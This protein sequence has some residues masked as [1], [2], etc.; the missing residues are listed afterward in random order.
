[1]TLTYIILTI[2]NDELDYE[3]STNIFEEINFAIVF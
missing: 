2:H 1:M 3:T